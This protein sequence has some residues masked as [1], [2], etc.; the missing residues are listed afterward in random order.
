VSLYFFPF[1]AKGYKEVNVEE[2]ADKEI[3]LAEQR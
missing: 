1:T 3:E 2:K